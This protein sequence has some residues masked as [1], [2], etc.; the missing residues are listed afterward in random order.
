MKAFRDLYTIID[1]K[2]TSS[3]VSTSF[4]KRIKPG[5]DEHHAISNF[6]LNNYAYNINPNIEGEFVFLDDSERKR[7]SVYDHEYLIRNHA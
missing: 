4:G 2:Y 6:T 3:S 5:S 1:A 7:F